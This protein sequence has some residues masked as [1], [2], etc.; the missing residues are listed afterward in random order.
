LRNLSKS[1][2][3][4]KWFNLKNYTIYI[5]ISGPENI[6]LLLSLFNL[7]LPFYNPDHY[8][9]ASQPPQNKAT[10]IKIQYKY[11]FIPNHKKNPQIY[12]QK[13][14][15]ILDLKTR[16]HK[17][18]TLPSSTKHNINYFVYQIKIHKLKIIN[19]N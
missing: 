8:K 16:N 17:S 2:R 14:L 10:S 7:A 18:P 15:K 12:K 5:Y 11:F 19:Q 3:I 6:I 1:N 13:I 4:P 9:Q